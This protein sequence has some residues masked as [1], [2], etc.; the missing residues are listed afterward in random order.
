M[1]GG[2]GIVIQIFALVLAVCFHEAAHGWV[3]WRN[4][5]PTAKLAGRITLN[6]IPHIDLFGTILFPAI[7]MITHAPILI[8]WAKPVPVNPR[9]FTNPKRGFAQVSIAGPGSNMLLAVIAAIALKV[10]T[11]LDPGLHDY[12]VR[13]PA[14]RRRLRGVSVALPLALF[15]LQSVYIN[16]VLGVFN[17]FPIPPLD[18]GHFLMGVLPPRQS[19]ALAKIEPYGLFIV[20]GLAYLGVINLFVR[21]IT[22]LPADGPAVGRARFRRSSWTRHGWT[23]VTQRP[24]MTLAAPR[25]TSG[26]VVAAWLSSRCRAGAGRRAGPPGRSTARQAV[27]DAVSATP[28]S[29]RRRRRGAGRVPVTTRVRAATASPATI[30]RCAPR[31]ASSEGHRPA[32]RRTGER[33]RLGPGALLGVSRRGAPRAECPGGTT[34]FADGKRNLHALHVQAGRGRR[35]LP[36]HDPHAARQP[37]LLRERIPA[38]R[39]AQIAQEFRGE[40]KGGWCKTG[41]H[42]PKSYRRYPG[43]PLSPWA[44][45]SGGATRLLLVV[46][47][48]RE[49]L[50]RLGAVRRADQAGLLHRLDHPRGAVVADLEAPL[51][52]RDRGLAALGD[53]RDG[54]VVHLVLLAV[55]ALGSGGVGRRRLQQ[56]LVVGR[57]RLPLEVLDEPLDLVLRD[58]GAVD[59][60]ELVRPRR[61]VEHVALAEQQ[62]G[63]VG[64]EHDARVDLR[65]DVERHAHRQVGLDDAGDDVGRGALR[66]D[67]QVHPDGAREL[68]QPRDRVLDLA[69]RQDHQVGQLVDDDHEERHQ[70]RHLAARLGLGREVVVVGLDVADLLLGEDLV[71][72]LHQADGVAQRVGRLLRVA[73]HRRDQVRDAVV[74]RQLDHLRVD[75]DELHLVGARREEDRADQRVDHHALARPGGAGDQH[76]RHLAQ[77]GDPRLAE[78]VLAERDGELRVRPA[79]LLREHDLL[80]RHDLAR[81]V[82]QLDADD[83]LA[84]DPGATRT[85]VAESASAR[86]SWRPSMRFI[87]IPAA[88]SYSYI[89]ITGPGCTWVTLPLTPKSA[90]LRSRIRELARISSRETGTRSGGR[91]VEQVERR[92]HVAAAGRGPARDAARAGFLLQRRRALHDHRAGEVLLVDLQRR[93]VGRLRRRF[94]RR[95]SGAAPRAPRACSFSLRPR[96]RSRA[97]ATAA[98]RR[99][100]AAP[101]GP[102]RCGGGSGGSPA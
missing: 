67:H 18:G 74:H 8:G 64:V 87:L 90:S 91:V 49:D 31:R 51:H 42:A 47:A 96:R 20:L 57:L 86:S 6:P 15:L 98:A 24:N 40:P 21:P 23:A 85:E 65:G 102:A 59:A 19:M 12:L 71:A 62:L 72:L 48:P 38:R 26:T 89:V 101:R 50:A 33:P 69:L 16:V 25:S 5:D 75:H 63:A 55:A 36:C 93:L 92:Q 22:S 60:L 11:M 100:R 82:R 73:D 30:S 68:R 95:G 77:V 61:Q 83:G 70:R 34:G 2:Q 94:L 53:D 39:E 4:G 97:R 28:Q 56:R 76:V 99:L 3:A 45:A 52:V 78:G 79:E 13:L 41:C 32:G 46:G 43:N 14:R 84:G 66:R 27:R 37:K 80:E 81:A 44:G 1:D 58:E 88:S 9:N 35:C 17:C 54:L 29:A 7:L 10:W